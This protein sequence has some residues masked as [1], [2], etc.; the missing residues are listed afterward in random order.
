M[1]F[2]HSAASSTPAAPITRNT[3]SQPQACTSQ[4]ISGAKATVAKYCAELKIEAAKPRSAVGNHAATMRLLPGNE[5][6]S[7]MPTRKR[8]TNKVVTAQAT[9]T[10]PMNPCSTVNSDQV[11]R[12]RPYTRREPKRSSNQPPGICPATYAQP[13]AEKMKPICSASMPSESCTAEPAMDKVAR[14]T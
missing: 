3:C 2:L 8:S 6:A 7:A 5:G 14:S 11:S 1:V 10:Q 13:N 4:P 9:G 12:D